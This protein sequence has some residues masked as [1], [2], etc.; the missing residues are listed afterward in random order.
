MAV[1]TSA[2]RE[3]QN[4]GEFVRAARDEAGIDIRVIRGDE[5]ARLIYLG[6]RGS[7]D[8][9]KQRVALFDLGGGSLEVDPRR[10]AGAVLTPAS[11][12]LGVIR[13]AETCPCSD[14]PSS[15]ER[16]Q[17]V[18]RVRSMLDPVVARVR[19]MGFDFVAFTSGTASAL[20]SVLRADK[21]TGGGKSDGGVEGSRRR[22][23]SAWARRRS[24]CGRACRGSTRGA[25]TRSTQARSCFARCWSW[26]ARTRRRCARPRC[27]RGSSPTTSPATAPACCWSTSS[28]ICAAAR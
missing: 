15:R 14:P 17:L 26:R 5:E 12:K 2:V 9:G 20:A 13:L 1:A 8:L 25:P 24:R 11:L 21:D 19:A 22:S 4:G 7:L 16:A 23:S 10:R 3:A 28:P 27:A 18:E 6:A